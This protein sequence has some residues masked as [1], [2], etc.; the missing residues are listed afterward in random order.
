MTTRSYT[1]TY[2]TKLPWKTDM[3]LSPQKLLESK[4][5][6]ST[7]EMKRILGKHNIYDYYPGGKRSHLRNIQPIPKIK[8]GH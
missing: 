2:Y 3:S 8:A 7:P 5:I 4:T 1:S 6:D